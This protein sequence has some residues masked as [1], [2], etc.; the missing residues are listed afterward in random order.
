ME[1]WAL[2]W[3]GDLR[4]VRQSLMSINKQKC[5][6]IKALLSSWWM[7]HLDWDHTSDRFILLLNQCRFISVCFVSLIKDIE[8]DINF[9]RWLCKISWFVKML[10]V[11]WRDAHTDRWV[12]EYSRSSLLRRITGTICIWWFSS[13]D[14]YYLWTRSS[15]DVSLL[16][17]ADKVLFYVDDSVVLI[18][19]LSFMGKCSDVL[20]DYGFIFVKRALCY[21]ISFL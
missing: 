9:S 11:F 7:I 2:T 6:L 15:V 13:F 3:G 8:C 17:I 19:T 12:S 5:Y 20:R 21:R 1:R 18:F 10:V 14:W 4:E 16:Y